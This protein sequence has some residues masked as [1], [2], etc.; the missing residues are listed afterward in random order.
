MTKAT[1][2]KAN[3]SLGLA[4]SFRGSVHYHHVRKHGSV[5]ADMRLER[6]YILIC[7]QQET[8][9]HRQTEGGS[10]LH[11]ALGDLKAHLQS[12][13]FPSTRPHLLIVSFSHGPSILK[14]PQEE[15]CID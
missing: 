14:P 4:Y 12:D 2:I 6:I 1:L 7:R 13:T 8:V 10:L 11:W 9:F 3:I 15:I 5:Q